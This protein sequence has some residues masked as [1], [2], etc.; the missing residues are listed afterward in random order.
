MGSSRVLKYNVDPRFRRSIGGLSRPIPINQGPAERL[1]D[2]D[3]GS[4][5]QKRHSMPVIINRYFTDVVGTII[6]KTDAGLVAAGMSTDYPVFVFGEFD[7][8]GGYKIGLSNLKPAQVGV[9][10]PPVYL[11]TFVNGVSGTSFNVLGAPNPANTIQGQLKQGDIVSVYTDSLLT[12]SYYCFMVQTNNYAALASI[13]SNLKSSQNDKRLG[14]LFCYELNW[15][16][17]S[18]QWELPLHFITSDNLGTWKDNPVQ[19]YIF[20]GVYQTQTDFLTVKTAFVVDQYIEIGLM[21]LLSTNAM[22]INFNME[23]IN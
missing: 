9:L 21:Y 18:P 20:D 6:D 15:Y 3:A 12:P 8:E 13:L 1:S 5:L 10:A 2:V 19:P 7:R 22:S 14:Q 23:K 11:L 17:P 16:A 4:T